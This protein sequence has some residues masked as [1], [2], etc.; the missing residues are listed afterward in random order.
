MSRFSAEEL[1][2]VYRAVL[3]R[4]DVR[5]FRPDPVAQQTL[6]RLLLAAHHGPSVGFMQPWNFIVI[7]DLA[8]KREIHAM[9]AREKELA[10][11]DFSGPRR[12][13]YDRLKLE[14]ILE[15]PVNLCVTCDPERFGPGVI[16][17]HTVRETDVFSVC[18]AVQNL[19]LAA[20]AEGLGVGWVSILRN[21]LLRALLKIPEPVFPVAYLCIGY[22]ER[23]ASRPELEEIGWAPRVDLKELIF[24]NGWGRRDGVE[25]LAEAAG[26]EDLLR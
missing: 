20:R 13:V 10:A 15:A 19:W 23:F 16:G 12:E 3:T 8:L 6:A 26:A 18:C 9:V 2:G 24:A 7:T 14:G 22:P 1:R 5:A 17:R 4:R 25:A 21:D 11:A